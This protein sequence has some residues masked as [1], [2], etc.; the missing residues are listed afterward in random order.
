MHRNKSVVYLFFTSLCLVVLGFFIDS[1]ERIDN[2]WVNLR[3]IAMM[4]AIVFVLLFL[5]RQ[6]IRIF[7]RRTSP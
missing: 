7:F 3:E 5:A 2:I 6:L 1:D 4:T